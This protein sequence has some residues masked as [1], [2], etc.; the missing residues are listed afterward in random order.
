MRFL[1]SF[2]LV[3][4]TASPSFIFAEENSISDEKISQITQRL[5]SYTTNELIERRDFLI[6]YEE[7]TDAPSYNMGSTNA[8]PLSKIE[9]AFEISIIDALVE[10][11]VYDLRLEWRTAEQGFEIIEIR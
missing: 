11:S 5:E 3:A 9:R 2:L 8:A 7:N 6:S 4:F 10:G 1:L